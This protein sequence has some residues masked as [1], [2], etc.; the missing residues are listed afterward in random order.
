MLYIFSMKHLFMVCLIGALYVV[1]HV[2]LCRNKS[3]VT[4]DPA[5][6]YPIELKANKLEQQLKYGT[7]EATISTET[8]G[9]LR[10][11]VLKTTAPLR[12][13][14]PPDNR[15]EICETKNHAYI[16]TGNVMFDGLYTMAIDE[17]VQNSVPEISNWNYVEG[18]HLFFDAFQTGEKWTYVWTRD[19]AYSVNLALAGFDPKRSVSSL[20]FKTS[21]LKN[22]VGD[23]GHSQIIQ[24]TGSGGSYPVSTDRVVWAIGAWE[25]LKFLKDD[26][27][28]SFLNEIYPTLCNTIEQ[29]RQLVYDRRDGL[30]SGEQSFLDWREQSYPLWTKKDVLPI[31]LSKALSV[32]IL[33]YSLLRI[34]SECAGLK[35]QDEDAS[36]YRQWAVNLKE[37]INQQFYDEESGLYSTYLISDG[38]CNIR[39]KRYDL[40]G[41]ALAVLLEVADDKRAKSIL[42]NYPVGPHGPSVV[43]PQERSVPIYH[44]QGIWP[45]VTAYWIKAA[46]KQNNAS[47]VNHGILTMQ[48]LA[49]LNLSNMENYDFVSGQAKVKGQ[50]LNGPQVNSRRQLWSVAGYLSMVQ[51]V[52]FGMEATMDG[53]RFAPY[54]TAELHNELFPSM[55]KLEFRNIDYRGKQNNVTVYLPGGVK[56]GTKGAYEIKKVKFN[57]ASVGDAYIASNRMQSS[58]QWDIYLKVAGSGN[59]PFESVN[60]VDVKNERLLYGPAMPEWNTTKDEGITVEEGCLKLHFTHPDV[61]N[62]SFNIYKDGMC[63]ESNNEQTTWLDQSSKDYT[64]VVYG[65]AIEAVDRET[66]T[67]S[68]LSTINRY[69]NQKK[70]YVI[71]ANAMKNQGGSLVDGHHFGDWGKSDH[72]LRAGFTVSNNGQYV[73]CT[74]FANGSGPVN[75]GITCAV[76]RL[77]VRELGSGTAVASGYLIMPQSGNWK[78]WKYRRR[79]L[80]TWKPVK[81]MS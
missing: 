3:F 74:E 55:D 51:S 36:R 40:L 22:S 44:N 9:G 80:P 43:S 17:A 41:N 78:R 21:E 14:L 79:L 75:T 28:A 59:K 33:N 20:L 26:E 62:V 73:I 42:A 45:F 2:V 58:N 70:S 16:R 25:A 68:H 27:R 46:C 76:K 34:T 66:G 60:W 47:A 1:P 12:D 35:Q 81:T 10:T 15:I 13:N 67:V 61:S 69:F 65:Y 5:N 71:P 24:D 56:K 52:M 57:G 11:Y 31:A 63:V 49:A 32:N 77:D 8:G 30:Y 19:L 50:A 23:K 53:L 39:V 64:S 72:E 54:L 48:R 4:R 29:D 6:I 18:K 37:A 7:Q 38:L